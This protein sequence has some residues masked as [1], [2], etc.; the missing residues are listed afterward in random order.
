MRHYHEDGDQCLADWGERVFDLRRDLPINLA[1]DDAVFFQF[2][3]VL[4]QYLAGDAGDQALKFAEAF[5]ALDQ[6]KDNHRLPLVADDLQGGF[7]RA[8][9]PFLWWCNHFPA[10]STAHFHTDYSTPEKPH[11]NQPSDGIS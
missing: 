5:C 6:M 1:V 2:A 7:H 11:R 3:E 9:R 4:R 8:A 10:Y